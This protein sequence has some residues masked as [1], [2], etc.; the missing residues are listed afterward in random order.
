MRAQPFLPLVAGLVAATFAMACGAS[1]AGPTI[2]PTSAANVTATS[3]PPASAPAA[4]T[5]L[6]P[7]SVDLSGTWSG[8]YSGTPY[9][10]NFT[11]DWTQTGSSLQGSIQVSDPA[12]DHYSISGTVTGSSIQFGAVGGVTYTG[13]VSGDSMSGTW[14]IPGLSGGSLG[15][16]SWNATKS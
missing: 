12:G 7:A 9:A 11:L 15:G 6:A 14:S 10:G 5:S 4:T 2:P 8:Q 3:P 16:G 13:T 1:A